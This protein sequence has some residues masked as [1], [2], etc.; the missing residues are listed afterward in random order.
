MYN[1]RLRQRTVSNI[2][3]GTTV[4][5]PRIICCYR[6]F[7]T[8]AWLQ[9]ALQ[10]NLQFIICVCTCSGIYQRYYYE[11]PNGVNS[12]L[13]EWLR[14]LN[15]EFLLHYLPYWP[16]CLYGYIFTHILYIFTQVPAYVTH[17]SISLSACSGLSL[18][19]FVLQSAL[20]LPMYTSLQAVYT[21]ICECVCE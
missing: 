11:T 13:A 9:W 6:L 3:L 2:T 15:F 20:Y 8:R 12:Q 1:I 17:Q 18:Y 5:G 10:C 19:T 16:T 21:Y 14:V 7:K 4:R